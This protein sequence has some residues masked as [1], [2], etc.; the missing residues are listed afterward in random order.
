MILK[1]FGNIPYAQFILVLHHQQAFLFRIE[2][3]HGFSEPPSLDVGLLENRV[4][5]HIVGN[6]D[7][8]VAVYLSPFLVDPE[9]I[10]AV[11]VG[12]GVQ[13]GGEA[14]ARLKSTKLKYQFQK[15]IMR[16]ILRPRRI[17]RKRQ[18]L[19]VYF[20]G[21]SLIKYLEVLVSLSLDKQLDKFFV[22][23]LGNRLF[24]KCW[25]WHSRKR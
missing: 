8:L 11:V 18:A 6:V 7:N 20:V 21:V 15:D 17:F 3:F 5:V 13:P 16:K 22:G 4:E 1:N 10:Y 25:D 14:R 2:R 12:D 23:T 9:L 19:A 24:M